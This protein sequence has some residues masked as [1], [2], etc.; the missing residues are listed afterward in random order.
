MLNKVIIL[1]IVSALAL[2]AHAD[3]T[4]DRYSPV[5]SVATGVGDSG[6]YQ[7]E[8]TPG[9]TRRSK[10]I[11]PY[12][13]G[14]SLSDSLSDFSADLVAPWLAGTDDFKVIF[15][16]PGRISG[17]DIDVSVADLDLLSQDGFSIEG[18]D[19]TVDSDLFGAGIFVDH[20]YLGEQ[21]WV[22][23]SFAQTEGLSDQTYRTLA[24]SAGAVVPAPGAALLAMLGLP[25]IA[26][27]KRRYG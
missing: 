9:I 18:I 10:S 2:P 11:N 26:W 3:I 20:G 16:S 15:R 22:D 23:G 1:A 21:L 14:G 27:A 19:T 4:P 5:T 24:E 12:A 8:V 25:M 6:L 7:R 13:T 17:F